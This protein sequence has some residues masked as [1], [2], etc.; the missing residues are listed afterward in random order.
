MRVVLNEMLGRGGRER[1]GATAT[2]LQVALRTWQHLGAEL[3]T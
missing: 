1:G 3:H 2:A